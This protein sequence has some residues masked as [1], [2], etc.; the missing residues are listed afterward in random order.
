MTLT[1]ELTPEQEVIVARAREQG[2]DV[3]ALLLSCID[4]LT[5]IDFP[6]LPE[7]E[8]I[9]RR[10]QQIRDAARLSGKPKNGKELVEALTQIGFIG[11]RSDIQ[12]SGEYARQLRR[13]AWRRPH[14][15]A[16]RREERE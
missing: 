11:S 15:Q 7:E 16:L 1:L 10:Q 12:D 5:E 14:I 8:A 4:S 13:R 3:D 6:A 2:V 9:L